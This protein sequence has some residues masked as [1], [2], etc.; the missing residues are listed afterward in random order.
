MLQSAH[1][2]LLACV[3]DASPKG[4]DRKQAGRQAVRCPKA[5]ERAA[6]ITLIRRIGFWAEAYHDPVGLCGFIAIIKDADLWMRNRQTATR[7]V[8]MDAT[9]LAVEDKGAEITTP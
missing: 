8:W 4:A 6:D 9:P 2:T 7:N 5:A 3:S 1:P